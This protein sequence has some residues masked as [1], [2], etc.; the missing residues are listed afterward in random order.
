MKMLIP[1]SNTCRSVESR[2]TL[3]RASHQKFPNQGVWGRKAFTLIELLIVIAVISILASLLVV[4]VN[5]AI[6]FSRQVGV[7]TEMAQIELALANAA[8]EL[9]NV[10]YIPSRIT[11]YED[12]DVSITEDKSHSIN[13]PG[14]LRILQM[15]FP[16]CS[17]ID[18]NQNGIQSNKTIDAVPINP[19]NPYILNADKS[20]VFFLGGMQKNGEPIGFARGTTPNDLISTKRKGPFYDFK[21]TRLNKAAPYTYLDSWEKNVLLV[22]NNISKDPSNISLTLDNPDSTKYPY[23]Y[24]SSSN[25]AKLFN[26]K[27]YQIISAGKDGRFAKSQSGFGPAPGYVP[28]LFRGYGDVDNEGGSDDQ[29]NFSDSVLAKPVD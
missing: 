20:W 16:G 17:Q 23:R 8:R 12:L 11:L 3:S 9:G 21:N 25:P 2:T 24:Y 27:G 15:M 19:T 7:K 1:V 6:N 18:W 13:D 10:P 5:K 28:I 22:Y 4:G 14:S 26:P 29:A